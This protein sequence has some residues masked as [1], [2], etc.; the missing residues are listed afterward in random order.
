MKKS[1]FLALSAVLILLAGCTTTSFA[2]LAKISYVDDVSAGGQTTQ[3]ELDELE[4]QVQAMQQLA[5]QLEAIIQEMEATRA[6][7]Q[8]LQELAKLVE[9]RLETLPRESLRLLVESIQAY[10]EE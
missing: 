7:T 2:G 4:S 6:A 10:L 5:D 9:A 3:E 1:L 8:E